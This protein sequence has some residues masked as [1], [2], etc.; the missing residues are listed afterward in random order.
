MCRCCALLSSHPILCWYLGLGHGMFY[1]IIQ[2]Y[3]KINY[4]VCLMNSLFKWQASDTP[5]T[6][7]ADELDQRSKQR[8]EGENRYLDGKTFTSSS[9]L[10]KAVR[11]SWVYIYR[12]CILDRVSCILMMMYRSQVG[13]WDSCLH[14]RECEVHIWPWNCLQATLSYNKEKLRKG[15][16]MKIAEEIWLLFLLLMLLNYV[17]ISNK[18]CSPNAFIFVSLLL[19]SL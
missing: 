17:V 13:R 2:Y 15:N 9:T 7:S 18:L 16:E 6:L 12:C 4:Y 10:S 5:F 19:V 3:H 8:M 1:L 14:G 11:K